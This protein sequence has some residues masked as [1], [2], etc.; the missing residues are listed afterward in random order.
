MLEIY[1]NKDLSKP[2]QTFMEN[3]TL[4]I[5]EYILVDG[6]DGALEHIADISEEDV[7]PFPHVTKELL[8]R[9]LLK[10]DKSNVER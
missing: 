3:A 5:L 1:E 7:R 2:V 9:G 6:I 4:S 10:G 8:E